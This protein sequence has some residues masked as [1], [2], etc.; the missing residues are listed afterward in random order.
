MFFHDDSAILRGKRAIVVR[1]LTG[2]KKHNGI[3]NC[4]SATDVLDEKQTSGEVSFIEQSERVVETTRLAEALQLTVV[5]NKLFNLKS[6]NPATFIGSGAVQSIRDVCEKLSGD[7]IVFD[8]DLS[9]LQQRNLEKKTGKKVLDRTAV[10]LEIF[11][12]RARTSEGMLQVQ[13]AKMMYQKT[14]LV[15]V[16]KH[17]ERQKG[18]FGFIG[19]PGESQLEVDRRLLEDRIVRIKKDLDKVKRTRSIQRSAR[20][21][22]PWPIIALVGYTNAGKSTLFNA[23]TCAEVEAKDQLFATLDPTMRRLILPSKRMIIMSDTVGFISELPQLLVAA[24]QA[25]LEEVQEADLLLHVMDASN[26]NVL[27]QKVAVENILSD[28]K[29]SAPVI[30]IL[31]KSDLVHKSFCEDGVLISSISGEGIGFLLQNIDEFFDSKSA[32]ASIFVS[33]CNGAAVDW[34][35]SHSHVLGVGMKEIDGKQLMMAEVMITDS[36]VMRFCSKFPDAV[37]S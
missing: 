22:V 33:P 36:N 15:R 2:G 25:T 29:C 19:G 24:F 13:L 16:W 7:I 1:A 14:R 4:D 9:P 18:G 23:L 32:Y 28:M 5:S 20:K 30:N 35:Y 12:N 6:I 31:N 34:L 11:G 26:P 37:V 21:K 3:E 27:E 8:P 17:L 10:I